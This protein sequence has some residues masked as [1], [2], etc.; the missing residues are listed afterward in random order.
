M[1]ERLDI[2]W[3]LMR[4]QRLRYAMAIAAIFISVGLMYLP[5]LIT[6]A[7]I[8]HVIRDEPLDPSRVTGKIIAAIGGRDAVAENLWLVAAAM[9]A[10]VATAGAFIYVRGK[11][12]AQAAESMARALRDQLYERLQHLP[13]AWFDTQQTGDLIQRCTS[14]VETVR[15]FLAAQLVEVARAVVLLAIGLP[16]LLALD[17]ELGLLSMVVLPIVIWYSMRFFVNVRESFQ[18]VDEAEGQLTATVQENL[19][20]V[21]VVRAFAR[22]EFECERFGARNDEY[23]REW[24]DL[25]HLMSRYWP[26]SGLMTNIQAGLVLTVG[27][28]WAIEGRISLGTL[29]AFLACVGM[30]LW[31]VRRV[32][33]ILADLGKA[34]VALGRINAILS[35]PPE[36]D[37]AESSDPDDAPASPPVRGE[38]AIEGLSFSHGNV[39]VLT[40]ISLRVEPGQTL[41]ILGPSG[42]GKST[43]INLLLRLYDYETGSIRL[44]GTELSDLPRQ[45]VRSRIG[46]VLQEPFLYSRSL[47]ENIKLGRHTAGDDAMVDAAAA[48]CMHESIVTFDDGYDTVVGERGVTLSGGQRQRVALARALLRQPPVLILDDA[49]SAVDTRTEAMIL[50]TLARRHGKQTTIVIAHRLTTLQ[51]ADRTLVLDAGRV[52]QE[53]THEQLV[54]AAGMYRRLWQIQSAVAAIDPG[55]A[56]ADDPDAEATPNAEGSPP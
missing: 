56:G 17:V 28:Y 53:G 27:A 21:R 12:S 11:W 7:A 50:R 41:A 47:R 31:P 4:G 36:S 51:H 42:S 22:Q 39:A 38:I 33:R 40:D 52:V 5:P 25:I 32:G 24:Y 15:L 6:R 37:I 30:Y 45:T 54:G 55:P 9:V 16:I 10:I 1:K 44:D 23:R 3:Q 34:L 48:A 20:G 43:L 26:V 49:L 35:A 8:D 29:T 14:D 46:V 2:L 13:V 18:R 19:T